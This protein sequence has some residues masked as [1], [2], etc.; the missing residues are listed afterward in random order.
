MGKRPVKR[1][2][3]KVRST[4]NKKAGAMMPLPDFVGGSG[5]LFFLL[6][7]PCPNKSY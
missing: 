5:G 3:D 2:T 7:K 1:C 4:G 6:S